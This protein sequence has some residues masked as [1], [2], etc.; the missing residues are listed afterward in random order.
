MEAQGKK[1]V[2]AQNEGVGSSIQASRRDCCSGSPHAEGHVRQAISL[3]GGNIAMDRCG[4]GWRWLCVPVLCSDSQK[5]KEIILLLLRA[6]RSAGGKRAHP[7]QKLTAASKSPR[8]DRSNPRDAAQPATLS[9]PSVE[10]AAS[11]DVGALCT[12]RVEKIGSRTAGGSFNPATH[13]ARNAGRRRGHPCSGERN[14]SCPD[15]KALPLEKLHAGQARASLISLLPTSRR[16]AGH[17]NVG[18]R[19]TLFVWLSYSP[20]ADRLKWCLL[21]PFFR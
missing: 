1:K 19:R 9:T 15:W 8:P 13:S 2:L 3:E 16:T 18:S 11:K 7:K 4:S 17:L 10:V 14:E 6:T 21:L 5:S 20:L 12:E